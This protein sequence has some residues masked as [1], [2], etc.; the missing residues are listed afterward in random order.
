MKLWSRAIG[1]AEGVNLN[2]INTMCMTR[3]SRF[4]TGFFRSV[5][6][7]RGENSFAVDDCLYDIFG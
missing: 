1:L 6:L 5:V 3:K 4:Q 2:S 7:S